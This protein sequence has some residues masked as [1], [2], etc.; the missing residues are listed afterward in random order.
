MLLLLLL[1]LRGLASVSVEGETEAEGLV[2]TVEAVESND[3][4]LQ[5]FLLRE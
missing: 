5:K 4:P 1:L 3:F 2:L